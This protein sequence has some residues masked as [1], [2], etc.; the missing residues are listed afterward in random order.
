[1]D[2]KIFRAVWSSTF[3]LLLMANV[4][5]NEVQPGSQAE[6]LL[7][8]WAEKS[9]HELWMGIYM[10]G[11]KVGHSH[12]KHGIFFQNAEE[13]RK[14]SSQSWMRISRLGGSSIEIKTAQESQYDAQ[15]RLVKTSMRM[16]MSGDNQ[17]MPWPV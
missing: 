11:I 9:T 15:H 4:V 7:R 10:E 2:K 5:W 12:I 6:N 14:S 8:A 16:K 3:V 13:Q 17:R 1:M